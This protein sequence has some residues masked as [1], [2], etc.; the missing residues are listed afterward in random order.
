MARGRAAT[1]ATRSS[2]VAERPRKPAAWVNYLLILAGAG[3]VAV[4]VVKAWLTLQA[5]PVQ[6]ISV[7]GKLEYTQ[8]EAV[9][10][11]VQPA[12]AD[13]FLGADLQEIRQR[14]Q[15]LPWIYDATVRRRWPAALEIHVVEQLPIARWGD[16]SFLNHEGEVFHTSRSGDWEALPLLQGPEGTAGALMATYRRMVAMLSPLGLSIEQLVVDERGQ[17][18]AVLAGGTRLVL[19]SGEFLERMHRFVELYRRELAH[20]GVE[21]ERVDLRYPSGAAVA[22]REPEPVAEQEQVAGR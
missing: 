8:R 20:S 7:T 1:G 16:A 14:L 3:V 21:V 2:P 4:A 18:D 19:G 5:V 22:F 11:I 12:V 9:Q 6:R 17:V 15:S 10:E 13:G